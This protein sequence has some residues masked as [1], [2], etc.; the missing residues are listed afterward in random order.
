MCLVYLYKTYLDM[1]MYLAKKCVLYT[2]NKIFII[3][4]FAYLLFIPVLLLLLPP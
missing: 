3:Y 2:M 4:L 1:K